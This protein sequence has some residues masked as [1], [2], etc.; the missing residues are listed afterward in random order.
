MQSQRAGPGARRHGDDPL[1]FLRRA[2]VAPTTARAYEA[3]LLA[4]TLWAK[5]RCLPLVTAV[6]WDYA[7]DLFLDM[8][9]RSG[10]APSGGRRL[11]AA[12]AW[13]MDFEPHGVIAS[14]ARATARPSMSGDFD[15]CVI[16]D[17]ADRV[18]APL[19]LV[20]VYS[21]ASS[22]CALLFAA[23]TLPLCVPLFREAVAAC[24]LQALRLCPHSLRHG[25]PLMDVYLRRALDLGGARARWCWGVMAGVRRYAAFATLLRHADL[26]SHVQ[27]GDAARIRLNIARLVKPWSRI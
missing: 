8:L 16:V 14:G 19:V 6:Q 5:S 17:F 23:L 10:D 4:C 7:I 1:G 21:S 18:F 27:R 22:P 13:T 15:Q 3:S 25:G 24:G 20:A 2:S 26:L 12:A 9:Y 11:I